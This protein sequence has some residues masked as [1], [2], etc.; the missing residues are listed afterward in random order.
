MRATSRSCTPLRRLPTL[1]P[2]PGVLWPSAFPL[3]TIPPAPPPVNLPQM[4]TTRTTWASRLLFVGLIGLAAK[5]CASSSMSPHGRRTLIQDMI[6]PCPLGTAVCDPSPAYQYACLSGAVVA[7]CRAFEAGPFPSADCAEQCTL[8]P[9]GSPAIPPCD[10]SVCHPAT[11]STAF[12]HCLAGSAAGGCQSLER[13]PF[14]PADCA[15][16]CV[17]VGDTAPPPET[18]LTV[19]STIPEVRP[20]ALDRFYSQGH[21]KRRK[22][23]CSARSARAPY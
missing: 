19:T 20:P 1:P 2:P 14:A 4:M 16:H 6:Y 9:H 22:R 13:G 21:R 7:M 3:L 18:F 15:S 23:P 12:Y 10:G 5:A 17:S 11:T 8:L